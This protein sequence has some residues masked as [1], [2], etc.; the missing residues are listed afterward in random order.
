[1]TILFNDVLQFSD[2]PAALLSPAL[3]DTAGMEGALMLALDRPRKINCVGIGNTDG[4]W[5]DFALNDP[6]ATVFRVNY[7]DAGLYRFP[8]G[9]TADGIIV[10]TD[11]TFI[12]RLAAGNGVKILTSLAKQP[13]LVSTAEPRVTL[14]GQVMPGRGGYIYRSL[15]LDSRYKLDREAMAEIVEGYRFTGE[16]Y[17]FFISLEEEAYKLWYTRLYAEEKDQRSLSF[18]GGVPRF[19]YSRRWTFTERF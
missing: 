16:G 15:S 18:E 1:M 8:G 6:A 19:L 4:S 13:G 9:V 3:S 5:F 2:A 14:S 7:E 10:T 11:A 12:G 17:P